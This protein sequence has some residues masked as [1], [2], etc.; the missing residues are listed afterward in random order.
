[1]NIAFLIVAHHRFAHVDRLIGVLNRSNATCYLHV[2]AKVTPLPHLQ[3]KAV[4]T[5]RRFNVRWAGFSQVEATLELL[6]TAARNDA[7]DYFIL[8]SGADYPIRPISELIA[9]LSLYRQD[10]INQTEFGQ[11]GK[12]I[13]RV[14]VR[15]L[16]RGGGRNRGVFATISRCANRFFQLAHRFV[17][18]RR[19]LPQGMSE[20]DFRAGSSW[21]GLKKSTVEAILRFVAERPDFVQ[22]CSSASFADEFFFQ[23]IMYKCGLDNDCRPNL[24]Y[25]DWDKGAPPYPSE[26]TGIHMEDL[27]KASV[28]PDGYGPKRPAFFARKF[29][30]RSAAVL[31]LLDE[32]LALSSI[33]GV[34][35]LENAG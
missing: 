6:R 24:H 5:D 8:L 26:L 35:R 10:C 22:Y 11:L 20:T 34:E 9:F 4:L 32:K 18:A 29:G 31:D 12:S 1:L 2:D 28:P 27:M 33:P 7:H 15:Y 25:A 3:N 17:G 30:A 16:E 14:L 23:T 13:D 21:F 19:K